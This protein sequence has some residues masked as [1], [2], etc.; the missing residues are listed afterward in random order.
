[1]NV[2]FNGFVWQVTEDICQHGYTY[3]T[4]QLRCGQEWKCGP[5]ELIHYNVDTGNTFSTYLITNHH[6]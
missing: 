6:L 2:D 4:V 1:M 3:P 5:R